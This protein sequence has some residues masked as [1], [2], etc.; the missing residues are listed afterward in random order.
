M[1]A[2]SFEEI[3]N[4]YYKVLEDESEACVVVTEEHTYRVPNSG[5]SIDNP[6]MQLMGYFGVS[7][8]TFE[9]ELPGRVIPT[10]DTV[11]GTRTIDQRVFTNGRWALQNADWI[12]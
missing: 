5:Y 6:T 2:D 12:Q 8:R 3:T 10:H 9:A 1:M 4:V 11:A 7:P